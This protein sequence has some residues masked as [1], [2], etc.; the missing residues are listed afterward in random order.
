V[1]PVDDED[2]VEEFAT[3]AAYEPLSDRVRAGCSNRS[4]DHLDPCAGEDCIERGGVL[5]VAVPD[6]EPEVLFGVVEV[7]SAVA[8][9]LGQPPPVG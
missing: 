8:R 6:E 5:R 1:A 4:L 9:Q 2:P 3:D 7:H